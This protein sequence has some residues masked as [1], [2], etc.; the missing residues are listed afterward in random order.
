MTREDIVL[1]I[2]WLYPNGFVGF[3]NSLPT[4]S[5]YEEYVESVTRA[6]KKWRAPQYEIYKPEELLDAAEK[7][8]TQLYNN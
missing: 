8:R 3:D 7:Y 5:T 1:A 6:G 4:P 2:S